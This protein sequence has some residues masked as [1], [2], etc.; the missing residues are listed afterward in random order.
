MEWTSTWPKDDLFWHL[1]ALCIV[2]IPTVIYAILVWFANQIYRKLATKLTEWENHRTES[3]FE[4]N[5]VTKLLL[6]EFVNNFMS[7]FYIAFY[8]QDIPML[9][10]QVALMLLVFQV[11]NQLTET[12]FPYLNLCYVLKKRLNVRILAPDNPIVKQAYKESLLEPYEGTIE[13]YLELYIQFGYVLLFVAAYPTA[14]LWAFI[15][16]VAELRVDA[17]KLVHIHRRP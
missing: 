11:I 8:L 4:S 6:F 2:S 12:L 16:N 14:S 9:Q 5:R 1:L 3:Q 17:F 15:N 10:W 7:L 13:D